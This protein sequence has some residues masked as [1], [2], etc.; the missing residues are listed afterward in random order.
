MLAMP[1]PEQILTLA[2][3]EL[4]DEDPELN[5]RIHRAP[6]CPYL[7]ERWIKIISSYKISMLGTITSHGDQIAQLFTG[8][9]IGDKMIF[10]DGV[11]IKKGIVIVK[12]PLGR[13]D[14]EATYGTTNGLVVLDSSVTNNGLSPLTGKVF[15]VDPQKDRFIIC[16][17]VHRGQ[18]DLLAAF[19]K[20]ALSQ[21]ALDRL[22]RWGNA[23]YGFR[24][25]NLVQSVFR[26]S[27]G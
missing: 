11:K 9:L 20:H 10:T 21:S 24:F 18:Q 22:P 19:Y 26:R 8:R 4:R 1:T 13:E 14:L 6:V 3:P 12:N 15:T 16:R 27:S 5:K 25:S 17:P 23:D 7:E 2:D